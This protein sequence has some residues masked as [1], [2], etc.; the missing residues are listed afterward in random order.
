M[1]RELLKQYARFAVEVGVNPQPCQTL[2]INAPI[3]G[4][5]FARLCG[6]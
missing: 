6:L 2:I 4:A 3:E 5:A 1:D